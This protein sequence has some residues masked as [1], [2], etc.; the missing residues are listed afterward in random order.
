VSAAPRLRH[1]LLPMA[2]MVFCN[3]PAVALDLP[4]RKPGLWELKV[5]SV[6]LAPAKPPPLIAEHCIDAETDRLMNITGDSMRPD[7]CSKPEVRKVGSTVVV[8]SVCEPVPGHTMSMH[9]IIA[10]EFD[11]AYTVKFTSK[12]EGP[13]GKPIPGIPANEAT[14][15]AKWLGPCK[16]GQRPGDM[17]MSDSKTNVRDLQK[18]PPGGPGQKR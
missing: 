1:Y 7:T 16:P 14:I 15:E 12:Q 13:G 6:S 3:V 2:L 11:S 8:D 9:A 10:G 4:T 5:V 17:I 18:P